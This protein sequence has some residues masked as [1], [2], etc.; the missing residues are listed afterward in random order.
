MPDQ[1]HTANMF[2]RLKTGFTNMTRAQKLL[3]WAIITTLAC[4][5]LAESLRPVAYVLA[6]AVVILWTTYF[7][8]RPR[9]TR[10]A[11]IKRTQAETNRRKQLIGAIPTHG[12]GNPLIVR[13]AY[14]DVDEPMP[15]GNSP[16]AGY[17]FYW[18]LPEPAVIGQRVM[19]D[20]FDGP[21]TGVVIGYG[22]GSGAVGMRLKNVRSVI[23]GMPLAKLE[24]T[25]YEIA[26][27]RVLDAR[28][29]L[30][31]PDHPTLVRHPDLPATKLP[32]VKG[33]ATQADAD[34]YG[35]KWWGIYKAAVSLDI[36]DA[37]VTEF[38]GIARRWFAM[39]DGKSIDETSSTSAG[40]VFKPS[41][42]PGDEGEGT[43]EPTP[44][45][46]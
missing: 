36:D 15:D 2:S 23:P 31:M 25:A 43:G 34:Q 42:D 24:P 28:A 18:R 29:A 10:Q 14:R 22:R 3:T 5:L 33:A 41:D 12:P 32:P 44:Y 26:I 38:E 45:E 4:G 37:E 1:K 46:G 19:V 20:G 13:V 30:G 21:S 27:A 35:R 9:P 17:S 40:P 39:R 8:E 16:D 11:R 7:L 6:V